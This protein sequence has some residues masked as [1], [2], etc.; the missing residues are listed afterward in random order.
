MNKFQRVTAGEMRKFARAT[1][2]SESP[3]L[4]PARFW[5]IYIKL[6]FQKKYENAETKSD[7]KSFIRNVM[8]AATAAEHVISSSDGI[9]VEVHGSVVHCILPDERASSSN[10]LGNCHSISDALHLIFNDSSKVEAWRMAADWGKTLLVRGRGIHNDDSYSFVGGFCQCS[11]E[12]P[13]LST[14]EID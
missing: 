4:M 8:R 7:G 2:I 1:N 14:G 12:I 10:V 5:H 13:F 6:E 3:S 9:V 11:C